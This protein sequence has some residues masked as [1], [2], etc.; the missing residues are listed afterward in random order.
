MPYGSDIQPPS[1]D[2]GATRTNNPSRTANQ[3]R[4][5]NLRGNNLK[6]LNPLVKGAAR[7]YQLLIIF[8]VFVS[9]CVATTYSLSVHENLQQ[10]RMFTVFRQV[11]LYLWVATVAPEL[12][13]HTRT[14]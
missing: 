10:L 3:R 7:A 6:V 1:P 12:L 4:G 14:K 5:R 9:T 2:E 11:S 13:V 8:D